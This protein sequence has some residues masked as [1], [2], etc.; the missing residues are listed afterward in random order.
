MNSEQIELADSNK[1]AAPAVH[2]AQEPALPPKQRIKRALNSQDKQVQEKQVEFYDSDEE[3]LPTLS[4]EAKKLHF[5][6]S[7]I[8]G[9]AQPHKPRIGEQV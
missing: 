5:T 1:I 9:V 8:L 7:K 6:T 4:A 2:L 3:P